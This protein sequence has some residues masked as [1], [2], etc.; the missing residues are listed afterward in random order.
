M[1][2]V[3]LLMTGY[4]GASYAANTAEIS[5]L[6]KSATYSSLFLVLQTDETIL[7]AHGNQQATAPCKAV[8]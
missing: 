1:G 2:H 7:S 8:H 4:V 5:F 6:Q 3:F